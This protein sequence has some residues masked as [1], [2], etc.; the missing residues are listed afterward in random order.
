MT[1]DALGVP[2]LQLKIIHASKDEAAITSR[3]L[4]SLAHEWVKRQIE[5]EEFPIDSLKDKVRLLIFI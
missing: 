2:R 3:A 1:R 5:E 4:C